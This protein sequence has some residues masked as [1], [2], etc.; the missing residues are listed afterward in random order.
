MC[1]SLALVDQIVDFFKH[2][3]HLLLCLLKLSSASLLEVNARVEISLAP[4][5][6]QLKIFAG[7]FF[8]CKLEEILRV[9]VCWRALGGTLSLLLRDKLE[10]LVL[11][12]FALGLLVSESFLCLEELTIKHLVEGLFFG[13][14]VSERTAVILLG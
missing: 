2:F 13:H 11:D 5:L 3:S 14:M 9:G 7:E 6:L 12:D 4:G 10:Q 1:I 8:V